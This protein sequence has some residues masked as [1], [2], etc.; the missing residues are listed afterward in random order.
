MEHKIQTMIK[1]IILVLVEIKNKLLRNQMLNKKITKIFRAYLEE[2][3]SNKQML[4]LILM[5]F[6][7][8]R[9]L[10]FIFRTQHQ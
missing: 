10:G 3:L 9:K 1:T 4:I 2:V 8:L 5:E 7:E 6:T